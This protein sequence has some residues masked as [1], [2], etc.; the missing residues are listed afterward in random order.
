LPKWQ[1]SGNQGCYC[2]DISLIFLFKQEYKMIIADLSYLES[3]SEVIGDI[4]GGGAF[5]DVGSFASAAGTYA[6]VATQAKTFGASLPYGASV[7]VG[8]TVGV[9]IAYTPPSLPS[10]K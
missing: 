7:A 1:P 9:A 10:F 4:A 6:W 2:T 5:V 3:T 8:T